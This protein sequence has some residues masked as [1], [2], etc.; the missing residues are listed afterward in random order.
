VPEAF[1]AIRA[2][3]EPKGFAFDAPIALAKALVGFRHDEG[4]G[5]RFQV[6]AADA[7]PKREGL[8]ATVFG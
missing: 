4:E 1:Q 2:E 5:R 7:P 8:W 6:L 3:L